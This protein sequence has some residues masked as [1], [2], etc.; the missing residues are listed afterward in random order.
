MVEESQSHRRKR[1]RRGVLSWRIRNP[2]RK[3]KSWIAA[4]TE[5]EFVNN[6]TGAYLRNVML[7]A[8]GQRSVF[9][10]V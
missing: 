2:L 7:S 4:D 10:V 5:G 9:G 1:H 8:V 6:D 3:K